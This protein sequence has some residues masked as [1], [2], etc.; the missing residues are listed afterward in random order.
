MEKE[1]NEKNIQS[2]IFNNEMDIM[3][4]SKKLVKFLAVFYVFQQLYVMFMMYDRFTYDALTQ[5][6]Q[7][8]SDVMQYC[9]F[10]YLL[11]SGVENIFKIIGGKRK[12]SINEIDE[13]N[14]GN[15]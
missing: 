7:S 10:A 11:K 15:G 3:T 13:E 2:L 14:G 5:F 8:N 12:E 4:F 9:I 6:I 1:T